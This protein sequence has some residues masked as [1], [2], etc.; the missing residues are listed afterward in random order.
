MNQDALMTQSDLG[1]GQLFAIFW[2]RRFWFISVF[3]GVLSVAVPMAL[4]KDTIYRSS[5]QLLVEPNYRDRQAGIENEFT[6][7]GVEI[8]YAT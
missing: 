7:S 4:L 5:M 2:R 3:F 6:D 8:D 1:Y